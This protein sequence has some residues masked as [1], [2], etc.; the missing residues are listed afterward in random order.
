[1]AT[2]ALSREPNL[3]LDLSK[4]GTSF[5]TIFPSIKTLFN[6]S[7]IAFRTGNGIALFSK[8]LFSCK[9]TYK[10]AKLM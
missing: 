2:I 4:T 9:T 10:L 7:I 3:A 5:S 8:I 1:L 6:P